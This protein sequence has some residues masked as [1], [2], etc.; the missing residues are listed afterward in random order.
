MCVHG[1]GPPT[2]L[3]LLLVQN[4]QLLQ[5]TDPSG[6][7][8]PPQMPRLR[9]RYH[10]PLSR[11]GPNPGGIPDA[12]SASTSKP[13]ASLAASASQSVVPLRAPRTSS[14]A[15]PVAPAISVP[16]HL[17]PLHRS[18]HTPPSN[19]RSSSPLPLRA[20]RLSNPLLGT[21]RDE[22][23]GHKKHGASSQLWATCS[24]EAGHRVL[25]TLTQP[26]T[27]AHVPSRQP[28]AKGMS[29]RRGPS[30]GPRQALG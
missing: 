22:V 19:Q 8:N 14:A 7:W 24:G 28:T 30:S 17:P 4:P 1:Q 29:H 23:T 12:P 16:R 6:F 10:N 9:K 2:S 11:L 18:P 15:R 5:P 21:P 3:L 13:P 20:P 25:G 26:H 27:E